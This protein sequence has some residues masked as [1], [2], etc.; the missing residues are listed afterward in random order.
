MIER[1]RLDDPPKRRQ[2]RTKPRPLYARI[3][4]VLLHHPP[5][6]HRNNN[7]RRL[8]SPFEF[9]VAAGVNALASCALVDEFHRRA[10]K[11][12]A[13]AIEAEQQTGAATKR[14]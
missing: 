4:R 3:T 9:A 5:I 11:G 12:G 6:K 10:L 1:R 7:D 13:K 14:I 2:R 8:V